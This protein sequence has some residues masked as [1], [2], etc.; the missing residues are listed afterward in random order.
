[1]KPVFFDSIGWP[2]ARSSFPAETPAQLIDCYLVFAI[3]RGTAQFEGRRNRGASAA[4]YSN[5]DRLLFRQ[6]VSSQYRILGTNRTERNIQYVR[7]YVNRDD[8]GLRLLDRTVPT[9]RM[10]SAQSAAML[11]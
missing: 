10:T 2:A 11:P 5:F 6:I 7:E 3:V 1:M 8:A 4:D 9:P